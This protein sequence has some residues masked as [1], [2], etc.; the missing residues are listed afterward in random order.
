MKGKETKCNDQ[1][2]N[3]EL[4]LEVHNLPHLHRPHQNAVAGQRMESL[5]RLHLTFAVGISPLN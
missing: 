2:Q 5:S 4:T 3:L 1:H